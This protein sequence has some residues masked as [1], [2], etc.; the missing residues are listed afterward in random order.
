MVVGEDGVL[1]LPWIEPTLR[2]ALALQRGPALLLHAS[3]GAG[4]LPLTVA[5]A[6]AWLCEQEPAVT[7]PP[8]GR[9]PSCRL[10]QARTHPD[11]MLLLP[12]ELALAVGWPADIDEKRKPSRQLRVEQV[13]RAQ[14]WVVTTR[15]RSRAKVL[16]LHPATALNAV[17]ASSLLKTIEEPPEGVRIVLT[18]SDP[19]RLLPTILSRCQRL[20]LPV[21]AQAAAEAWL[22]AQGVGDAAVMLASAGGLPLEALRWHEAGMTAAAWRALPQAVADGR[23]EAFEGWP[24]SR[25]VDALLKLCHDALVRQAG[26]AT[27]FFPAQAMTASAASAAPGALAAW[28]RRLQRVSAQAEHPWLEGLAVEALVI[29]GSQALAGRSNTPRDRRAAF[30]TL[31]R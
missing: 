2:Q 5:L 21:P 27:R 1:P 17:S 11:L 30:A 14:D 10:V 3:A 15:A 31:A 29:E 7:A 24:V 28:L 23:V 12:E 8:C 9:C 19:A 25:V 18:A 26:G 13:R 6:Q 4:A 16:A 20:A 22:A